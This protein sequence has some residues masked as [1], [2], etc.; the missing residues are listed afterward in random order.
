MRIIG[1][2]DYYDGTAFHRDGNVSSLLVYR[3]RTDLTRT[4]AGMEPVLGAR[5]RPPTIVPAPMMC[6]PSLGAVLRSTAPSFLRRPCRLARFSRGDSS[7]A[8]DAIGALFC[9][10]LRMGVVVTSTGG[11]SPRRDLVVRD[12]CWTTE[13]LA[14][15]VVSRGLRPDLIRDRGW[16]AEQ[17]ATEAARTA[18]ITVATMDPTDGDTPPGTW[19]LEAPTLGAMAFGTRLAPDEAL[20]RL[21]AWI[22]G[23]DGIVVPGRTTPGGAA[24]RSAA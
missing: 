23:G 3:R 19:R 17:D 7:V 21:A 5:R 12:W 22:G 2:S 10:V 14:E 1:A 16:F 24:R 13:E 6:R 20:A 8:F 11:W 4:S 9:G 18:G 15:A